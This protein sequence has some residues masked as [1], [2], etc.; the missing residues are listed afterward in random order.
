MYRKLRGKEHTSTTYRNGKRDVWILG[1]ASQIHSTF[2]IK[3]TRQVR[4]Y[5]YRITRF[6]WRT[7]SYL[8]ERSII[9][10]IYNRDTQFLQGSSSFCMLQ[11]PAFVDVDAI[12][13]AGQIF[14]LLPCYLLCFQIVFL[15][16]G[17]SYAIGLDHLK[18]MLT[19]SLDK[20]ICIYLLLQIAANEE[21]VF[22]T[23]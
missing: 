21:K 2:T 13:L 1:G 9:T 3:Q 22:R 7:W 12:S 6:H 18:Y 4:F 20:V 5:S 14:C 17:R 16:V 11:Q 23:A 10:Y 15:M 8:Y 19:L